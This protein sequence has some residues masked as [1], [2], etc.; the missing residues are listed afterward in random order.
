MKKY[1]DLETSLVRAMTASLCVKNAL[2]L[3][4]GYLNDLILHDANWSDDFLAE[5]HSFYKSFIL[6]YK[7][8]LCKIRFLAIFEGRSSRMTSYCLLEI[9]YM[10]LSCVYLAFFSLALFLSFHLL[11]L[12]FPLYHV[13]ILSFLS[14]FSFFILLSLSCESYF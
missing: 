5:T 11:F 1:F 9:I 12:L 2:F 8:F 6:F 4:F 13:M 3:S 7:Q 10:I 14:F